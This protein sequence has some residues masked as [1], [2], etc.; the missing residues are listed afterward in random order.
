MA[1]PAVQYAPAFEIFDFG[2]CTRFGVRIRLLL[3]NADSC[4]FFFFF[5]KSEKNR[6]RNSRRTIFRVG[7]EMYVQPHL[8]CGFLFHQA[9]HFW[10]P[11]KPT[12]IIW[13]SSSRWDGRNLMPDIFEAFSS[14]LAAMC[15][16]LKKNMPQ[17][18][19]N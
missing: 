6:M 17:Q 11:Q 7:I 19:G 15:R 9:H 12:R 3:L 5:R 16:V 1:S 14:H 18:K 13:K 8:F 4:C 10:F 2:V